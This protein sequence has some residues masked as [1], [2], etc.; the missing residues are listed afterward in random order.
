MS[1]EP[2]VVCASELA[3]DI[4]TVNALCRRA[5]G[6]R[7]LGR[8]LRVIDAPGP[9]REL[10]SFL[11]LAEVVPGQSPTAS[12]EDRRAGTSAPCRGRT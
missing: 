6:A 1:G 7:R 10:L 3:A 11:G 12:L 8:T 2:V 9:L 4:A 5:L